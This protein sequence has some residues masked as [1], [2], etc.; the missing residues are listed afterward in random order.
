MSGVGKSLLTQSI[1]QRLIDSAVTAKMDGIDKWGNMVLGKRLVVFND[2]KKMNKADWSQVT[3]FIR[4][5]TTGG[6]KRLDDVKYGLPITSTNSVAF[7][8]S[9]NHIP[10]IEEHDRRWWIELPMQV[11]GKPPTEKCSEADAVWLRRNLESET[12]T[13]IE[14]LQPFT[15]HLLYLY[16]EHRDKYDTYLYERA[17][18]TLGLEIAKRTSITYSEQLP[19]LISQGP[20]ALLSLFEPD[21]V[22]EWIPFILAQT[23]DGQCALSW[24]FF[25]DMLRALHPENEKNTP[26][27]VATS[28]QIDKSKFTTRSEQFRQYRDPQYLQLHRAD[29]SYATYPMAALLFTLDAVTEQ[30]YKLKLKEL[31]GGT[32]Q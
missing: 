30:E 3:A 9:A 11:Y 8:M 16:K 1:P 24:K 32:L 29:L 5:R 26:V 31:R 13:Y 19:K 28:M 10:S 18:E 7:A 12:T 20:E 21:I 27:K 2:M 15:N 17:P 23:H 14:E 6:T 22:V 4:D 25:S